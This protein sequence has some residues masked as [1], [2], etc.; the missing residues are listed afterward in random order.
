MLTDRFVKYL[1]GITNEPIQIEVRVDINQIKTGTTIYEQVCYINKHI[2]LF[3]AKIIFNEKNVK[4]I[5]C[6]NT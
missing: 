4:K 6:K 1:M 3:E 5:S 2:K